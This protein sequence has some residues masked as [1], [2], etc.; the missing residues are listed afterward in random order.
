MKYIVFNNNP[1]V[2]MGGVFLDISKVLDKAWHD[3]LIF[4]LESYFV[5]CELLSLLKNYFQ[6]RKQRD[7]LNGRRN[8]NS[9]VP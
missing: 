4:K 9:E 8:I 7:V 6:N 3:G 2:N 1:T 5:E